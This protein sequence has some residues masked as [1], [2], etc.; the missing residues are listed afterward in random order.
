MLSF[1]HKGPTSNLLSSMDVVFTNM[2][3]ALYCSGGRMSGLNLGRLQYVSTCQC[4]SNFLE[5]L[6]LDKLLTCDLLASCGSH[7]V[8]IQP[9]FVL[10][11]PRSPGFPFL[12]L[13]GGVIL[14]TLILSK[15]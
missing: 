14:G 2:S 3:K 10:T 12:I 11:A 13:D 15:L 9:S 8:S 6:S 1:F 7:P 4:F 5:I